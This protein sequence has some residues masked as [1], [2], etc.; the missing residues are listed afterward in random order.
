MTAGDVRA[1]LQKACDQAG[2][3]RAW[4]RQHKL[5]AAYVSDILLARRGAGPSILSALG[6]V[7]IRETTYRKVRP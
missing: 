3:I 7:A 2:G 6:L 4:A 5:S 1:M